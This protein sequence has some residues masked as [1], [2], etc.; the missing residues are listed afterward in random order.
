MKC[1]NSI[2]LLCNNGYL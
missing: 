2:K 1:W